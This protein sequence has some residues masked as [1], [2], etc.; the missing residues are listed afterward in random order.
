M[1]MNKTVTVEKKLHLIFIYIRNIFI[2]IIYTS[3]ILQTVSIFMLFSLTFYL[4]QQ[5]REQNTELS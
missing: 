5:Q 3:S 1:H 4:L 2:I